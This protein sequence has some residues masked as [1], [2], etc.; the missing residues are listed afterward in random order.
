MR[1]F[2]ATLLMS[3]GLPMILAGD[4]IGRTQGGNNNAYC[5]DS[6]I[7][8]IDWDAAKDDEAQSML[9]FTKRLIALRRDH[10]VF[11]R[12]RY[13]HG[14]EIPGTNVKDV[15]WLRPDGQE[16][17]AEDWNRADAR[18]IAVRLSGE[19]GLTH[20]SQRGE[21]EIDDTF[22]ILMNVW[23]ES[24]SFEVPA[25]SPEYAWAVV[26]DT[27]NGI[28]ERIYESGKPVT[29][30]GRSLQLL[31]RRGREERRRTMI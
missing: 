25:D 15:M 21:Q 23:H 7:G 28:E 27:V 22:V 3:Q 14:K 9:A 13:F 4:E 31:V 2:M 1:N 8:W 16:M 20:L 24:I 12:N 6:E 11:H 18:G 30:E 5:Q 29:V 19:A 17:T 26:L 10:I